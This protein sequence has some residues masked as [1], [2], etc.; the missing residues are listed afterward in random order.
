MA[1]R[2]DVYPSC[3]LLF[4][5]ESRQT[6]EAGSYSRYRGHSPMCSVTPQ[7][8]LAA[9]NSCHLTKATPGNK[10]ENSL[11][12]LKLHGERKGHPI[13]RFPARCPQAKSGEANRM[14]TLKSFF[15]RKKS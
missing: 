7:H 8:T 5:M 3:S 12:T 4:R 14:E 13:K 1:E 2:A 6:L 11:W 9:P 10:G 15:I